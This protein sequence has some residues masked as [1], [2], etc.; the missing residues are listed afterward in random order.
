MLSAAAA[1]VAGA[2]ADTGPGA[3]LLPL[4]DGVREV[5]VAVA[6][7]VATAA[8]GEGVAT[9]RLDDVEAAVRGAMW[10]PAYRPVRPVARETVLRSG[11]QGG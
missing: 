5:S 3:A 8:A 1:A 4:L 9:R 7:A 10:E 2:V 6:C 11:L